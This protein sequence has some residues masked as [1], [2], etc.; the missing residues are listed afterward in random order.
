MKEKFRKFATKILVR[1]VIYMAT[2][3][4][5]LALVVVLLFERFLTNVRPDFRMF[6][7]TGAGVFFALLA[8]IAYLRLDGLHMPKLLMKRVNIKR[9]PM[10]TYGDMIDYVDEEPPVSFD[11]LED[12]EK[13]ICCFFSDLICCILFIA[14]SFF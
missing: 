8:W 7:F 5:L 13:D 1:P 3:R 6:G 11:D 2:T 14:L 9:K 10:R 12:E 4:F